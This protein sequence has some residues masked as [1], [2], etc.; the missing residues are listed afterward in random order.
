MRRSFLAWVLLV[1]GQL[2][3]QDMPLSQVLLPENGE[4]E[5]V[6][7]G[8]KQTD[9]ACTDVLGNFY[10]FDVKA[11]DNILKVS[12]DGKL[13]V[14]A[15]G[16]ENISGMQFGPDGSLY[17][18]QGGDYKRVIK[19]NSDGS[20]VVLASNIFPN[21]LVVTCEAWVYVTETK[22]GKIVSI[23]PDGKVTRFKTS[24]LRPNGISLSTDQSVLVVSDGGGNKVY[25]YRIETNGDLNFEQAYMTLRTKS[26]MSPSKGDGMATDVYGRYYVTSEVGIQMYDPTGRMG[27]VILNPLGTPVNSVVFSGPDLSYMYICA[28]ESIYRRKTKSLGFCFSDSPFKMKV[29]KD[30]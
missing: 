5:L 27:G 2:M 25:A 11:G 13:S 3:G 10:F 28:K 6:V 12:A 7:E 9:A 17:A 22:T 14:Y 18:C 26:A 21:D 16:V 30:K 15:K 4:W 24:A 29:F 1:I 20:L 23:S 19:L 8:Y